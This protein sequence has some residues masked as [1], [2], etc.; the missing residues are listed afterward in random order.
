MNSPNIKKI[1]KRKILMLKNMYTTYYTVVNSMG[2][3]LKNY[4]IYY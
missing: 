3:L 4:T 2:P 1:L